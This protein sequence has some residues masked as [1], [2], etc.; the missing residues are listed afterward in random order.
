MDMLEELGLE[1]CLLYGNDIELLA[2]SMQDAPFISKLRKLN[3]N[4]NK[5]E[6][7]DAFSLAASG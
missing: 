1:N 5:F 7:S 6:N 4:A 3:F 2:Q